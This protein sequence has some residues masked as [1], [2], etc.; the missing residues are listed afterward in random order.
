MTVVSWESG[1]LRVA[2]GMFVWL[3]GKVTTVDR[4][5]KIVIYKSSLRFLAAAA[6]ASA[7]SQ[8]QL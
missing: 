5:K 7:G 3:F 1:R 6:A 8:S 4:L 2:L